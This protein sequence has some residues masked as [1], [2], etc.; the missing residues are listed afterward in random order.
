M[1]AKAWSSRP[2]DVGPW[3][4]NIGIV[5]WERLVAATGIW[6]GSGDGAES[7]PFVARIALS[8]LPNSGVAIHYEATS[9]EEGLQHVEHSLLVPGPDGRALLHIAH[10]ES[11]FVAVMREREPESGYFE[12]VGRDGPYDMAVVIE[13]TESMTLSYAWW[14]APAREPL[15]EQ[16]KAVVA[17]AR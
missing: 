6:F 3:C 13:L 11:P 17:L 9:R 5:L 16:S 14:W 2:F 15:V 1:P 8:P 4:H 7:G 12:L 10:S